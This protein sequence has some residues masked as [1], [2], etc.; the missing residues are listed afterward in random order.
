MNSKNINIEI[1]ETDDI[2]LPNS[3]LGEIIYIKYILLDIIKNPKDL[4]TKI[5]N[6]KRQIYFF[7]K[8]MKN[9]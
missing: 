2:I 8:W 3:I 5:Q 6:L 7:Q 4:L 9:K 1:D